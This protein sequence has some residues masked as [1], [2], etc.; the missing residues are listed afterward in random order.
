AAAAAEAAPVALAASGEGLVYAVN[1]L[2]QD[3]SGYAADAVTGALAPLPGSPFPAH[4]ARLKGSRITNPLTGAVMPA[5]S[6]QVAHWPTSLTVS[7][8]GVVYVTGHAPRVSIPGALALRAA[9][10]ATPRDT[11]AWT[12]SPA[13]SSVSAYLVDGST[14]ALTPVAGS[15]WAAGRRPAAIALTPSGRLAFVANLESHDVSAFVVDPA[16]GGLTEVAGSPFAT[17]ARPRAVAV[18]PTGRFL[19][20]AG[21]AADAVWGHVIDES[22]GALRAMAPPIFTAGVEPMAMAV[23][24]R[25]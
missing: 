25:R 4:R 18:D 17:G 20:V 9:P 21:S 8:S 24:G 16:T 10:G 22:T 2:S 23:V 1:L 19:Y 12:D 6:V 15:P 5:S 11:G 7:P 13:V 3:I 14:G